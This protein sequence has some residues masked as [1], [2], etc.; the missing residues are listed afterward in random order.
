MRLVS[1]VVTISLPPGRAIKQLEEVCLSGSDCIS[2]PGRAVKRLDEARLQ[3]EVSESAR[4]IRQQELHKNLQVHHFCLRRYHN[5][6]VTMGIQRFYHDY[7]Q[8]SP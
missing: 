8:L 6:I 1:L 2:F 3:K 4:T 7:D 5:V